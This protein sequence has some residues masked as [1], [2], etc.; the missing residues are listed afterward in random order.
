MD[1]LFDTIVVVDIPEDR[2]MELLNKREGN[3][4]TILKELNSHNKIDANKNKATYLIS[5]DSTI[6]NLEKESL[7]VINKLKDRLG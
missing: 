7:K 5:N 6:S 2:Q 3:R 4:A 1:N